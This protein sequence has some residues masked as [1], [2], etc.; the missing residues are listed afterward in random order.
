MQEV[1]REIYL[2]CAF[3]ALRIES[4]TEQL[5]QV[6]Y[7]GYTNIL[8]IGVGAGFLRHCLKFFPQVSHTTIDIA[9]DL[10]PDYVGSVTRMPFKD[11]QFDLI[12]CCEV[13]EHMPFT[14]FLPALREMRRVARHRVI[15]SLPDRTRHFGV[16][17]CLARLGWVVLEW[18]PNRRAY[19]TRK[20]VS[21]TGHHY[22]EIGCK[23]TLA[24]DVTRA[25]REAGFRIEK[26]YRLPKHAWHRFFILHA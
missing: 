10:S 20:L 11:K 8:E 7:S 16:A 19:A 1:N 22:W 5:R 17:V 14:D 6:C 3:D 26:Q 9:G 25:I 2:A 12:L 4:I 15:L 23:K 24:R 18:N 13:L 21:E